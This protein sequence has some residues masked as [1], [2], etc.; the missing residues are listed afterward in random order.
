MDPALGVKSIVVWNAVRLLL[1]VVS[2]LL[3]KS[4]ISAN[5]IVGRAL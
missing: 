3:V 2:G 1:V 5:D 4:R